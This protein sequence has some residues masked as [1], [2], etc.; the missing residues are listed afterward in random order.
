MIP[1]MILLGLVLGRWWKSAL[2]VAAVVWPALLLATDVIDLSQV[3]GTALF[4]LANAAVG[5]CIHQGA[6][7]LVRRS[8][9]QREYRPSG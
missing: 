4:G 7:W 8:G 2:A 6:W 5:V 3:I 9:S 1:T